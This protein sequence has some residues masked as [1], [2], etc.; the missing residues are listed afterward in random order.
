[1]ILIIQ[2]GV[3]FCFFHVSTYLR[4]WVQLQH[5]FTWKRL[6]L[7][8]EDS[9]SDPL[10]WENLK[11]PQENVGRESKEKNKGK[12]SPSLRYVFISNN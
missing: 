3:F 9:E 1:M 12:K 6:L 8:S 2:V 5:I 10:S 4:F 7:T 11:Q